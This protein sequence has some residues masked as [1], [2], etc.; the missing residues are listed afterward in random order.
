MN[1]YLIGRD[2]NPEKPGSYNVD[3]EGIMFCCAYY[4]EFDGISWEIP[5][6]FADRKIWWYGD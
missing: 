3:V 5:S 6:E 1:R 2:K 4:L